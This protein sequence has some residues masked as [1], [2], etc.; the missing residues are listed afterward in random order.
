M[1]RGRTQVP[2]FTQLINIANRLLVGRERPWKHHLRYLCEILPD[3]DPRIP[4]WPLW[5]EISLFLLLL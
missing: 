5:G 3:C 4:D 1:S 2:Y